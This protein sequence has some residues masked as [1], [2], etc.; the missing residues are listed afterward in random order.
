M[1]LGVQPSG[2]KSIFIIVLPY[3]Y[4]H[5][6][7]KCFSSCK[8]EMTCPASSNPHPSLLPGPGIHSSF[9]PCESH[10]S[11]GLICMESY[12][13]CCFVSGSF[14]LAWCSQ[15]ASTLWHVSEFPFFLRLNNIPLYGW[16]PL[17]K[18]FFY[19]L[20]VHLVGSSPTGYGTQAPHSGNSESWLLDHQ[21]SPWMDHILCIHSVFGWCVGCLHLLVIMNNPSLNIGVQIFLWDPVF[22]SLGYTRSGVARSYGNSVF[23]ILRNNHMVFHHGCPIWHSHQQ[24][25]RVL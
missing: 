6:S 19:G 24:C 12:N 15:S 21:G 14:H 5:P 4:H 20:T 17:K 7:P 2:I 3:H 8:A 22:N 10:C 1:F 25:T 9:C 13:I 18:F 23:N 16:T 11:R